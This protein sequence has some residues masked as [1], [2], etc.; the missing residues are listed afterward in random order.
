MDRLCR[1]LDKRL[2]DRDYLVEDYSIADIAV[3]PW[4]ARWEWLK[5]DWSLY[6]N[7]YRWFET[8]SARPAVQRGL[9]AQVV[10]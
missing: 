3:Y 4:T 6:P 9:E 8:I 10:D 5:L 2:A 7:L 1:V